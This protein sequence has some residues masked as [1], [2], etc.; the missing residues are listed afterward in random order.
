MWVNKWNK[1]LLSIKC[2]NYYDTNPCRAHSCNID[3]EFCEGHSRLLKKYK[4]QINK[5]SNRDN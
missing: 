3:H 5:K 1:A 2:G 4:K